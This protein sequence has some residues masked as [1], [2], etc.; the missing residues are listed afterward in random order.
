VIKT[1]LDRVEEVFRDPYILVT[2]M[3]PGAVRY[4]AAAARDRGWGVEP[5]EPQMDKCAPECPT[6]NHRRPGGPSGDWC[7]TAK[8][9]NLLAM[10]ATGV[11]HCLAF[12]REDGPHAQGQ[13]LRVGQ[14]V[15]RKTDIGL[16]LFV[17]HQGS[18]ASVVRPKSKTKG[19]E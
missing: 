14:S 11:D 15:V 1:A 4:A 13:G 19:G 3:E 10:L 5:H 8:Y 2:D 17:Q 18:K 6:A 9:R 16:W 7:P 12:V